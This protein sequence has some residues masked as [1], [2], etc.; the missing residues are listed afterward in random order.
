M[1]GGAGSLHRVRMLSELSWAMFPAR[2]NGDLEKVTSR[3]LG[4]VVGSVNGKSEW[5]IPV[6]S[7]YPPQGLSFLLQL[8]LLG[9]VCICAH[10]LGCICRGQ[11]IAFRS[12]FFVVRVLWALCILGLNLGRQVSTAVTFL[13]CP[14]P[15]V[16][17]DVARRSS[18]APFFPMCCHARITLPGMMMTD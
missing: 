7:T 3:P 1:Q 17:P 11:K 5:R 15:L 16:P 12:W 6:S 8:L 13:C 4:G 9:F 10:K 2:E 14:S 18:P